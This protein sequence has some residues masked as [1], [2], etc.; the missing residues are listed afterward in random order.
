MS[1]HSTESPV[2]IIGSREL[3]QKLKAI[4]DELRRADVRYVL[5][6]HG[7]PKAVLIGSE[8]YLDLARHA[9]GNSETVASLQLS[10]MLGM[11][12]E[13]FVLEAIE[14]F[15]PETDGDGESARGSEPI[16]DSEPR[17][18]SESESSPSGN[19][20]PESKRKGRKGGR[21]DKG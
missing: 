2:R 9:P 8:A 6:V 1:E 10:A 5:T 20:R 17:P 14:G 15:L 18:G 16:P 7:K 4:L 13:P 21:P 3:H 12:A 19:H 11:P